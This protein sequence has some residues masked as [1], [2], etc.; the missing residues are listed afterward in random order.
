MGL[1]RRLATAPGFGLL[2]GTAG[3][4]FNGFSLIAADPDNAYGLGAL[5]GFS[6]FSLA[7]V[8]A[9]VGKPH[10]G[11][12]LPFGVVLAM[13]VALVIEFH[14]LPPYLSLGIAFAAYLLA[15]AIMGFRAERRRA[16]GLADRLQRELDRRERR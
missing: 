15:E 16:D 12:C 8:A 13:S 2:I 4:A 7:A 3:L 1:G 10:F 5:L 9:L 6:G 11:Q 14:D